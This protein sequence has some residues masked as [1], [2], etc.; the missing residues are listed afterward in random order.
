M[1]SKLKTE[2][3]YTRRPA[4]VH[5]RLDLIRSYAASFTELWTNGGPSFF[6]A[7]RGCVACLLR[8]AAKSLSSLSRRLS[9]ALHGTASQR[10]AFKIY[11]KTRSHGS[12]RATPRSSSA[13]LY[14]LPAAALPPSSN[15]SPTLSRRHHYRPT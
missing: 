9:Q 6:G 7:P 3:I 4:L 15:L 13:A 8:P 2:N 5:I 12:Q 11:G 14:L 1:L 10:A